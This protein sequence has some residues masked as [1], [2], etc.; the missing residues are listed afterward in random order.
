MHYPTSYVPVCG[1]SISESI[2]L[3]EAHTKEI[4]YEPR[5]TT[6]VPSAAVRVELTGTQ[7]PSKRRT[8]SG[9]HPGRGP[10]SMPELFAENYR[11]MRVNVCHVGHVI[12]RRFPGWTVP[13]E[14]ATFLRTLP[15]L[16]G[17][18]GHQSQN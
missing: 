12:A 16:S 4:G 2:A 5:M 9:E 3:A 8:R 18:D 1:R 6:L 14:V 15:T 17:H 13:G 10:K 11:V 7:R